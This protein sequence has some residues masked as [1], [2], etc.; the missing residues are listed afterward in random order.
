MECE[1]GSEKP[2]DKMDEVFKSVLE[3]ATRETENI[4]PPV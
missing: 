2:I 1:T 3:T 4:T